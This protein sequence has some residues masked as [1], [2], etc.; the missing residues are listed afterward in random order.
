MNTSHLIKKLEERNAC[1]TNAKQRWNFIKK[2]TL[3]QKDEE[4]AT[5]PATGTSSNS[6]KVINHF[7]ELFFFVK[8]LSSDDESDHP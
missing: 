3:P 1:I 4:T 6:T 7:T 2:S 8:S 5:T